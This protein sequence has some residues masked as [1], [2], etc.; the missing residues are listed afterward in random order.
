[1]LTLNNISCSRGGR[2]LFKNLG[3][4]LGDCCVLLLKG[5]NGSGKTT[6]LNVVAG[7]ITPDSGEVLYANENVKGDHWQEYCEMVQY[8]GH[9]N[10]IKPKLTVRENLEFWA[11]L[12]DCK[13]RIDAAIAF[14]DLEEF[15]NTECGKLSAG[16]QRKVA[17]AKLLACRSEI[18]LLDEPFTNLDEDTKLKLASMINT[19]CEQG[20]S[21]IIATHEDSLISN[22]CEINL[23]EFV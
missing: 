18:W 5:P 4:T 3:F 17:L 23:E 16:W 20:G 21:V 12:R 10:A 2:Q 22:A 11:G 6:L 1:M 13:D 19:R 15:E 8:L 14:F 7:F 9:K